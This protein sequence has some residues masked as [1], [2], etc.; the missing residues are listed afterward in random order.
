VIAP[1]EKQQ[2]GGNDIIQIVVT[3]NCDIFNCSNCTQL[4]PFRRDA[5]NMSLDCAERA[6]KSMQGWPGVV[7]LFGG[8]P[9]VHP[10]FPALCELWQH[11]IPEQRQRGLWTNHLKKHGEIIHKTLW[12][13]GRFNLNVHANQSALDDM[14]RWL[15]GIPIY[16]QSPSWHGSMLLDY[17]DFGFSDQQWEKS[18]EDCDINRNW[19]AGVYERDGEP[20]AYFCEVAGSLD[21]VRGENNGIPCEPGWWK[22]PMSEFQHQVE[23]CC[24]RGCGVPLRC[25]GNRDVQDIYDVSASWTSH[26]QNRAGKINLALCDNTLPETTYELTDYQELRGSK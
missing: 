9:C 7:A 17:R 21:G 10:E 5:W 14:L 19:S 24:N 15:P 23:R 11:Y 20:F 3:R 1:Y 26:T 4:L 18:R 6:L 8:N 2:A 22:K 25:K 16:G 13:H 12:P